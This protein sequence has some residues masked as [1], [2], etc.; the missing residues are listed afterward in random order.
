[1]VVDAALR[2]KLRTLL[3]RTSGEGE[4]YVDIDSKLLLWGKIGEEVGK[5]GYDAELVHEY[6]MEWLDVL[7]SLYRALVKRWR[8]FQEA[9]SPRDNN[10]VLLLG[11]WA[12]LRF[13]R[14]P[15]TQA[16]S[17]ERRLAARL[18]SLSDQASGDMSAIKLSFALRRKNLALIVRSCKSVAGNVG[19]NELARRI[20][21]KAKSETACI[22][23]LQDFVTAN[24]SGTIDEYFGVERFDYT[25]KEKPSPIAAVTTST[26][27]SRSGKTGRE[28]GQQ[29]EVIP[30]PKHRRTHYHQHAFKSGKSFYEQAQSIPGKSPTTPST[31]QAPVGDKQPTL[32]QKLGVSSNVL[33]ERRQANLCLKCGA[34][35]HKVAQCPQMLNS[36]GKGTTEKKSQ[37]N[38]KN[39][40]A[41]S[42]YRI[43]LAS[44]DD[45][46]EGVLVVL[47]NV[48]SVDDTTSTLP[49]RVG[50][51]TYSTHGL[52]QSDVSDRL[53]L[54]RSYLHTPARIRVANGKVVETNEFVQ[55]RVSY[56]GY[57]PIVDLLLV[58]ELPNADLILSFTQLKDI[59]VRIVVPPP[60]AD[61]QGGL[62]VGLTAQVRAAEAYLV[63]QIGKWHQCPGGKDYR[64]RVRRLQPNEVK[65][66]S[67][68]TLVVEVEVNTTENNAE[69]SL[70]GYDYSVD[71]YNSLTNTEKAEYQ[72]GVQEFIERRWWLPQQECFGQECL[73]PVEI[74]TFPLSQKSLTTKV[75]D[76]SR[77]FYKVRLA[78]D[79]YIRVKTVG[80]CYLRVEI[81]EKKKTHLDSDLDVSHLGLIW[82]LSNSNEL[83]IDCPT[84][85]ASRVLVPSAMSKRQ[86][87]ALCGRYFDPTYCHATARLV[88]NQLRAWFGRATEGW[89]KKYKFG[90]QTRSALEQLVHVAS[91]DFAKCDH[92]AVPSDHHYLLGFCDACDV[93]GGCCVI[94]SATLSGKPED[95]D[96]VLLEE[97]SGV[98]GSKE[99][100]WH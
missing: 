99:E 61:H 37:D 97:H 13:R 72:R 91:D 31:G 55:A 49:L 68:Q 71:L 15:L 6:F 14:L 22:D 42:A 90:P 3:V 41:D 75:L 25:K 30:R 67:E 21:K 43:S 24:S 84:I 36:N 73:S 52:I 89:D 48:S 81:P 88:M 66:T 5:D 77:A 63:N 93:G 17:E 23:L 85:D 56:G 70:S 8:E 26:T 53:C 83:S 65:D 10:P 39:Q 18:S 12:S 64:Y 76:L 1:T 45:V 74:I 78:H 96:A 32:S 98:F 92:K 38:T 50:L 33:Q 20:E 9:E 47:A 29:E 94:S 16:F 27:S 51:D 100:K 69:T 86:A 87:F 82:K 95:P 7:K 4:E 59:G 34:S 28:E 62:N 54:D 57:S 35:G 79:K 60:V 46:N 19:V 58:N 2:E 80:R 44:V 11:R 40:S